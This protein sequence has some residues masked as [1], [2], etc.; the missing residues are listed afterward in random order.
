MLFHQQ[1]F[2]DAV[3]TISMMMENIGGGVDDIAF[4]VIG[5]N[6]ANSPWTNEPSILLLLLFSMPLTKLI[7]YCLLSFNSDDLSKSSGSD[8]RTSQVSNDEDEEDSMNAQALHFNQLSL[9]EFCMSVLSRI[10]P[11]FRGTL[12]S[13]PVIIESSINLLYEVLS[14]MTKVFPA[15]IWV[16]GTQLNSLMVRDGT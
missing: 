6:K 15:N 8:N 1:H 4:M 9:E 13:V 5:W 3:T 2:F 7:Y 14:L 12:C 11:L 16:S 10:V